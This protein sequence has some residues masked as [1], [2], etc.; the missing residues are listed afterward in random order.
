MTSS[1]LNPTRNRLGTEGLRKI[2]I[3]NLSTS[4]VV[5]AIGC[6]TSTIYI[7]MYMYVGMLYVHVYMYM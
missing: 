3:H 5:V 4:H 1:T 7:Y 2:A 6:D